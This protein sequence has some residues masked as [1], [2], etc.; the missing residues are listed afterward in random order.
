MTDIIF[1]FDTVCVTAPLS[2][3]GGTATISRI[4]TFQT[5]SDFSAGRSDFK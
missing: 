2:E 5:V 1:S 3:R 4:N